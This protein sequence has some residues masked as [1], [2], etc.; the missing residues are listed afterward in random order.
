MAVTDPP[1]T[2]SMTEADLHVRIRTASVD[3]VRQHGERLFRANVEETEPTM[4]L[5]LSPDWAT[6][7]AAEKR[8]QLIVLAAWFLERLV[9]YAVAGLSPAPHYRQVTICQQDLLYVDPQ[10]RTQRVGLR[11]IEQMRREATRRGA[12]Q[13]F[14]HAKPGSRLEALLPRIG[15]EVEEI[16][17]KETLCPQE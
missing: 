1:L 11:L 4:A 13:L 2:E 17:F 8:G 9:G 15:F 16:M 14:M 7:R 10:W 12:H 6:Y 3:E 5:D